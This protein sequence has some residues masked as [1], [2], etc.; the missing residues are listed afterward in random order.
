MKLLAG[1][2]A[3]PRGGREREREREYIDL[4]RFPGGLIMSPGVVLV[5]LVLVFVIPGAVFYS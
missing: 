5:V 1:L 2:Q 4:S 3:G